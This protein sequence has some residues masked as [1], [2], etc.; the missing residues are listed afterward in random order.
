MN[1][2]GLLTKMLMLFIFI[3]IGILCSK[4]KII[5]EHG[6]RV[7][8]KIV[9]YVCGPA[10][11]IYSV[12]D[13][14]LDYSVGKILLLFVYAIA[15]NLIA[16]GFGWLCTRLL[17]RDGKKRGAFN[18]TISFGNIAFMG[19]P[20]ISALYGTDAVFLASVCT[21]P[22]NLMLYSAGSLLVTGG[23]GKE[24]PWRK[25]LLNPSLLGTFV[26]ILL[27][28]F[29]ISLPQVLT[30]TIGSLANMVI[31]LSMI[32]I[33][34]SLG[35]MEARS[36]LLTGQYYLVCLCK[37]ILFPLIIWGLSRAL[38]ADDMIVGLLTVLALMPS[39]AMSSVLCME[40]GGDSDFANGSIFIT[41]LLSLATV[42]LMIYLL[43]L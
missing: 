9:L 17:C 6:S 8:N 32:L 35:R 31:P 1:F 5:D 19:F 4:T 34:S 42:P 16:L 40:Y 24:L 13:T 2:S 15:F 10:L 38:I 33:G 30:D 3:C 7:I 41:T 21:M 25:V 36:I 20:I 18:L 26:A 14:R 43:L 37:L 23:F 22:F 29:R 11:M 27:F 12:L 28:A 39:A